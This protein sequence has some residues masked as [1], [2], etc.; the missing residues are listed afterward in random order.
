MES[1]HAIHDLM[2]T[3]AIDTDS[4]GNCKFKAVVEYRSPAKNASVVTDVSIIRNGNN[5]GAVMLD[6]ACALQASDFHLDFSTDWQQYRFAKD[7]GALVITGSSQ[8]MG[9]TYS[10]SILPVPSV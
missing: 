2:E 10:V 4:Y 8:K 7:R 1:Y 9:G 3:H 5:D 6:E